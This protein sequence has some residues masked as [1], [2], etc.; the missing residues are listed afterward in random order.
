VL[1]ITACAICGTLTACGK[2]N[3]GAD[4]AA[5]D[6]KEEVKLDKAAVEK[7]KALGVKFGAK[8][9]SLNDGSMV[10]GE[11][12]IPDG[13]TQIGKNAFAFN[14]KLTAVKIP[15]S[16]KIIETHAFAHC[17]GLT[18]A[19][20]PEKVTNISGCAFQQSG[21]K[22][23]VMSKGVTR[24]EYNAF[25]GCEDL[26]SVVIPEGVTQIESQVFMNC[27]NLKNVVIPKSVTKMG[28]D[29]F[30]G[31]GCEEQVKKDY[32]HLFK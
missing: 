14:K 13:V 12:A 9:R 32:P 25:Y 16:V 10:V 20:I 18:A 24:I 30:K 21:V 2:K 4:K 11:Y 31:A 17:T 3:K 29:V 6:K 8:D 19:V 15:A 22:S 28:K 23:V 26:Q 1:A 7:S 27:K 5:A